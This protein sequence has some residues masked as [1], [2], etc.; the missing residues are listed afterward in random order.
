[1]SA[2]D[3]HL[4]YRTEGA[5]KR[6][7]ISRA[8]LFRLMQEGRIESYKIGSARFFSEEAILKFLSYERKAA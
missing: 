3:C 1:M 7:G 6:L 2:T 4:V 8:W 5:C